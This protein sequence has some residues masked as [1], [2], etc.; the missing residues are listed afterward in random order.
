MAQAFFNDSLWY[1]LAYITLTKSAKV[2]ITKKKWTLQR[3]QISRVEIPASKP[4]TTN[5]AMSFS[6]NLRY[7]NELY[8]YRFWHLFFYIL[9]FLACPVDFPWILRILLQTM[10]L[11]RV[12]GSWLSSKSVGLLAEGSAPKSAVKPDLEPEVESTA[13]GA[14]CYTVGVIYFHFVLCP[15]R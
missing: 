12:A 9:F 1:V 8:H 3:R 10:G 6:W 11:L 4:A 5:Q 14:A 7:Q 15:F 13:C 2:G